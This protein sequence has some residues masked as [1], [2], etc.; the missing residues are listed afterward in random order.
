MLPFFV[1]LYIGG[2]ALAAVCLILGFMAMREL[3]RA[4]GSAGI[5]PSLPIGA[6]A[7]LA[8]YGIEFLVPQAERGYASALWLALAVFA[9]FLYLFDVKGRRL[10][11][12][13]AT[14]TGILY[15]GFLSFHITLVDRGGHPLMVWL[16]FLSAFGS[17]ILAYL[18]GSALGRHKL[19]PA[20][21]PKKTVEGAIGG[22]VGGVAFCGAFGAL[23]MPGLL[24][25]CL[26]VG[27][28]GGAV[29]QLGDLT[30]SIFK[31]KLGIKDY[32]NLIPGH[33]GILDRI[34]SVLFTAPLVYYYIWI[35]L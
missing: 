20:I 4:F 11:D 2:P 24:A 16:I 12:G 13:M 17:D 34:D 10:E 32:G 3:F 31:R 26:A 14:I 30:A 35:A 19:C 6:L 5:K 28:I 9:S 33:G 7:L 27:L 15:T 29:S 22:L 21:S 25:H 1:V 8:L 23:F 18:A